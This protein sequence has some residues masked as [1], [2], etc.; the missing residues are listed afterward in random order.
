MLRWFWQIMGSKSKDDLQFEALDARLIDIQGKLKHLATGLNS[1]DRKVDKR[2]SELS[3]AVAAIANDV[4]ELQAA[5]QRV[6]E[7][8]TKPTPDVQSAVAALQNADA[9][10]DAIRDALNAAGGTTTDKAPADG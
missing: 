8:L 5:Q 6:I 1:L 9:G 4:T 3:D 10:F 2:M 7:L